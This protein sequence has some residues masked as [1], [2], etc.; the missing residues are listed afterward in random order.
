M[1]RRRE[2]ERRQRGR[3]V[4][5]NIWLLGTLLV[6]TGVE[7]GGRCVRWC[8]LDIVSMV[9]QRRKENRRPRVNSNSNSKGITLII[10]KGEGVFKVLSVALL[11]RV[12][13]GWIYLN[14]AVN[15]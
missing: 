11:G 7:E 15:C 14:A 9:R 5:F 12:G 4:F 2:V 10:G 3:R 1:E 8:P 6:R 13:K